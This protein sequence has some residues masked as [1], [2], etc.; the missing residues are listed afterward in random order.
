M[1]LEA[2]TLLMPLAICLARI[3]DVSLGTLRTVAVVR[4]RMLAASLLGFCEVSIWV[5]AASK[6]ITSL[7]NPL[8]V[9]GYAG[10]FALG[11]A[12]GIAIERRLALGELVLRVISR[13]RGPELAAALRE[14]G[15]RVTEFDG[16][17]RDGAVTMLYLKVERIDAPAIERLVL[18][19]DPDAFVAVEDLRSSNRHLPPFLAASRLRFA[20]QRK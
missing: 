16:R 8:N 1:D 17:G 20:L 12:V 5:I 7:T 15:F 9:I 4:G 6:V 10:G 18:D 19:K 11:N 3:L 13:G 14:H 2:S